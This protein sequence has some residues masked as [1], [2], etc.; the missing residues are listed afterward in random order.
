MIDIAVA[1]GLIAIA[2]IVLLLARMEVLPKKSLPYVAAAL[3]S[4]LT[5]GLFKAW[6]K[7]E[8][9]KDYEKKKAELDRLRRE[10]TD[11]GEKYENAHAETERIKAEVDRAE[12]IHGKVILQSEARTADEKD[13]IDGLHGDALRQEFMKRFGDAH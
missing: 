6:R 8:N 13:K 9:A 4:A 10:A 7:S 5:F 11:L 2:V 12:E 1:L 3:V